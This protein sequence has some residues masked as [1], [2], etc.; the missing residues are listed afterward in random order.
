MRRMLPLLLAMMLIAV[1]APAVHCETRQLSIYPN[2]LEAKIGQTASFAVFADGLGD[3]TIEVSVYLPF[4]ANWT[5]RP[6]TIHGKGASALSIRIPDGVFGNQ[7]VTVLGHGRDFTLNATAVLEISYIEER[8]EVS[9]DPPVLSANQQAT[10]A[11]SLTPQVDH[12]T[13]TVIT[14]P[15]AWMLHRTDLSGDLYEVTLAPQA[16]M[17]FLLFVIEAENYGPCMVAVEVKQTETTTVSTRTVTTTMTTLS[18]TTVTTQ[19]QL[20]EGYA[21]G[22]F[23]VICILTTALLMVVL[24]RRIRLR[25]ALLPRAARPRERPPSKCGVCGRE[26]TTSFCPYCGTEQPK[27]RHR[28]KAMFR[29]EK[30]AEQAS[31]SRTCRICGQEI[32]TKFCPHCGTKQ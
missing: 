29:R 3:D 12:A 26:I 6:R 11:V 5:M 27:T 14:V 16:D 32:T 10:V 4:P 2:R 24:K 8:I 22:I 13:L 15:G 1:L 19:M 20:G 17:M 25:L 18:V 21:F 28:I 30:P 9:I 31:G 7:T 23:I